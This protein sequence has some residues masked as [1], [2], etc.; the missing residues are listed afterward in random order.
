MRQMQIHLHGLA[1]DKMPHWLTDHHVIRSMHAA[2]NAA[3]QRYGLQPLVLDRP[4]CLAAQ[5]WAVEMSRTGYRHSPWQW[6]E[7]IHTSPRSAAACVQDWMWSADHR[8]IL[9]SGQRVGFGYWR[10]I[11]GHTYWVA[12]V[13]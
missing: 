5:R 7:C 10:T 6:A 3:R 12:E 8:S 1:T 13:A 9:L 2:T 11:S 4:M